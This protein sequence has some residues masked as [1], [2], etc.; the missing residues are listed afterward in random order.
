MNEADSKPKG[1][2]AILVLFAVLI[3][4]LWASV[5]LALLLRGATQ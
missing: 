3:V 4:V 5:Y 1:T 2:I